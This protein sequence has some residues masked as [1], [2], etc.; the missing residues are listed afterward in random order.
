[1]KNILIM[2]PFVGEKIDVYSIN[3]V[4]KK[5]LMVSQGDC[6]RN[7]YHM[8]GHIFSVILDLICVFL[9]FFNVKN[10]RP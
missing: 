2:C 3:V 9:Y 10:L 7:S 6:F 8:D 5:Y 1:M 4:N